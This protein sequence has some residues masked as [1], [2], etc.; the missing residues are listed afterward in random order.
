MNEAIELRKQIISRYKAALMLYTLAAGI[1]RNIIAIWLVTAEALIIIGFFI[2]IRMNTRLGLIT[3]FALVLAGITFFCFKF[4]T[5]FATNLMDRSLEFCKPK[6][7]RPLSKEIKYCLSGCQP[8]KTPVGGTFTVTK[9]T[10]PT[11]SQQVILDNLIN[12]LVA[13]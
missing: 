10:F 9:E 12:L 7:P 6:T 8:L 4:L 2:T 11:V 5:D 13:Y 3:V 1:F